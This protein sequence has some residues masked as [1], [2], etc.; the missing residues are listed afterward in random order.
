[1]DPLHLDDCTLPDINVR[2][3]CRYTAFIIELRAHKAFSFV[4]R[5]FLE[6][7][8][9]E[10]IIVIVH[11]TANHEYLKTIIDTDLSSYQTRLRCVNIGL[12]Q[13]SLEQ[14]NDLMYNPQLYDYIPTEKFLVF[15]TDSMIFPKNKN[16][17]YDY[18]QYDYVGGPWAHTD[19]ILSQI[20]VGNGGLSLRSKSK[21]MELL[22]F[23]DRYAPYQ[24]GYGKYM[25]EDWFYTGY[26]V[27]DVEVWRPTKA[28]AVN[29][30]IDTIYTPDAF[31]THK[32]WQWLP[33]HELSQLLQLHPDLQ[34]LIWGNIVLP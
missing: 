23:R 25:A 27:P 14:Y 6:N 21:M 26:F 11:G 18:L 32:C 4:L 17:I 8:G 13:I 20:Q 10:W 34:Q 31:G 24:H 30:S 7:L 1:M 33:S 15:Q 2:H 12:S 29:F 16:R 19:G 22:Q 28:Q 9:N 3:S 5:N